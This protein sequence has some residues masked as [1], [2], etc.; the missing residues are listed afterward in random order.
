MTGE[1]LADLLMAGYQPPP[2]SYRA[3]L[4]RPDGQPV[5]MRGWV[6]GRLAGPALPGLEGDARHAAYVYAG[7]RQAAA[8]S[9]AVRAGVGQRAAAGHRPGADHP[10][11]SLR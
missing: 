6:H 3:T 10:A 2:T 1:I 9:V 7:R 5:R 11:G 4:P 8:R